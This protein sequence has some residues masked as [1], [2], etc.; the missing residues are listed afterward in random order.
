MCMSGRI[1]LAGGVD[2]MCP[3]VDAGLEV[4][5]HEETTTISRGSQQDEEVVRRRTPDHR[6]DAEVQRPP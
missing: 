4:N 5:T 2:K 1:R 3:R 6:P